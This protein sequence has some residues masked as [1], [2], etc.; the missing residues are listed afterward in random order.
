MFQTASGPFL[1][2]REGAR[3][4]R[5]EKPKPVDSARSQ[6]FRAPSRL[7]KKGTASSLVMFIG[8]QSRFISSYR[9]VYRL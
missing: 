1:D 8:L 7:S 5:A 6:L 9:F 2:S 4:S 3:N